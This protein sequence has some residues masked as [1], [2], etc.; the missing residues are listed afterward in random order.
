MF[1]E[2]AKRSDIYAKLRDEVAFLGGR[3]PTYEELMNLKYVKWS[4]RVNPVVPGNSRLA[5]RN[6]VVPLGGGPDGQQPLFVPKGTVL[7]YSSY[8]VH[9]RK[10]LYG[11]DADDYKP[12]RWETLRPG[13]EYLPFNGGPRICLGQQYALNQA[14]YVT[15][16]LVQEFAKMQSRDPG[17]WEEGLTLTCY[18]LN[19]TKVG[20]TPA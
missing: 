19:G 15:V 12:E 7:G 18:S 8:T 6:T 17:P 5:I 10:D 20:L 2:I 13:W 11:P 4:L 3:T 14:S 16:R 9:R 1:F